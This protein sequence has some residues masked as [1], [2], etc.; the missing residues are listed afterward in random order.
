MAALLINPEAEATSHMRWRDTKKGKIRPKKETKIILPLIAPIVNR[1][2][3]FLIDTFMIFMPLSYIVFYVIMGSREEFK[4]HMLT[5][6]IY[7]L[8]PHFII[9]TLFLW[10]KGQTPGYKAYNIKLVGLKHTKVTLLQIILRY[11]I[12]TLSLAFIPILFMPFF[13]KGKL[14]LHD[15]L[16]R[17]FP[18]HLK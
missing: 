1:V 5:G 6:W 18:S 16:S 13:S 10:L 3:A 9:I 11:I 4:F 12:F 2:K 15:I 7:I 14:A 17:T 8:I